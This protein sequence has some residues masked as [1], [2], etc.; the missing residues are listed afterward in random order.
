VG[1]SSSYYR[2]TETDLLDDY[3][4]V[5]D[6]LTFDKQEKIEKE[7][8]RN[9]EESQEELYFIKGKLQEKDEEIQTLKKQNDINVDAIAHF[10]EQLL[11]MT[12]K[13][14]K[15]EKESDS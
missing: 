4:K 2:P 6:Q 7:L 9:H 3:L 1:I 5:I 8:Q 13:I 10:S 12:L 11:D 15:I 14:K